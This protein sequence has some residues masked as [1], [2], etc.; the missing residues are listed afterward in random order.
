[1]SD[2]HVHVHGHRP[3]K[4]YDLLMAAFVT[5]LLCSNMI[6]PGKSVAVELLGLP[7]VF[8]AGNLFFPISYIIGDVL[9]EVYGY[10]KARKVIWAGF[11][12][13]LFSATM[14]WVV[15]RLPPNPAEPFNQKMQPALE[16]VFGNGFRIVA[17]SALA[18]W[19]GDFAN[20]FVLAK[21]KLLTKGRWLWTRTIGSTV[22][23]E[24]VDSVIFYPV[25]FAG[26]WTSGT[27]VRVILF[28]WIF[29]IVVEVVMTPV[30]YAVVGALKRA[31]QEDY[32]D[33]DTNFTPFSL[34]D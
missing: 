17:A 24:G 23:G 27:L 7:V 31:E 11:G 15:T 21:M 3:Y 14:A 18:F 30:T 19:A 2:K 4:Y 12:A 8:G 5:D 13:L 6:G 32:F 29:K 33:D 9:T 25:A 22:V 34:T 28:N 10:A 1:M 26:L 16:V 20:S